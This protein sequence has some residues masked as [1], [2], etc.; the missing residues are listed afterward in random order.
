L[1]LD[2]YQP[3]RVNPWLIAVCVALAAFMEV[4]DTSIASVALPYI[5]G[6]IGAS[7]DEGNWVITSYLVANAV[8]LPAGSW[9]SSVLG[10]KRFFLACIVLFTVSSFLCGIAPSLGLLLLFRVL[11]GAAGGGLVPVAQAILSDTFPPAKRAM[12]FAFFGVVAVLAPSIGPTLGGWITDNYSW[13]WIFFINIPV[14]ILA[15]VLNLR[16][17]EDPPTSRGHRSNLSKIDGLGFGLLAL[18]MGTLQ[19]ALDKGEE[20]DWFGSNYIVFFAVTAVVSMIA[21]LIWEWR[22][23]NPLINVKLF[24]HRNFLTT[25]LLTLFLGASLN[26]GI[27]L[28]PLLQQRYFGY[29]ATL[30]G[31][32]VAGA[33]VSLI[34]LFVLAGNLTQIVQY[35]YIA[36]FGF[37]A[38]AVAYYVTAIRITPQ[39]AFGTFAWIR[40]YQVFGIAFL[41][42]SL[43]SAAYSG[44]PAKENNQI[45]GITNL[46]RNVGGSI[47]IS[48]ANAAVVE[49]SQFFQARIG[50]PLTQ[51]NATL[52]QS[53]LGVTRHLVHSGYNYAKATRMASSNVGR[54]L[55]LHAHIRAYAEVYYLIG[56]MC[57]LGFVGVFFLDRNKPGEGEVHGH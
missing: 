51:G 19:I 27:N 52:R 5:S 16:L 28:M 26:A 47:A 38:M 25:C 20:K 14:G 6:S 22:H 54:Q 15:F 36:G 21:L 10:R 12:A 42:T 1:E 9:A 57:L 32:S 50:G 8:V 37:L 39:D 55:D 4:L 24:K 13:R 40:I 17:L 45:S 11:Q 29:T 43:T 3:P 35:R 41:F 18:A 46:V 34:F 53:L 30:A 48:L 44:L 2:D 33:G 49:R 56:A 31:L 23:R 7:A